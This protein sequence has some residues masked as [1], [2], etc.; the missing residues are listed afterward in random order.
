MHL[1]FQG[2]S[3]FLSYFL[4]C[5]FVAVKLSPL[6]FLEILLPGVTVCVTY[7]L[8]DP[9]HTHAVSLIHGL[10]LQI[11]LQP[12]LGQD[13]LWQY[14]FVVDTPM[15]T[16]S[17][18]HKDKLCLHCFITHAYPALFLISWYQCFLC[19]AML[20]V[21]H[22]LSRPLVCLRYISIPPFPSP[23]IFWIPFHPPIDRFPPPQLHREKC[24]THTV[25]LNYWCSTPQYIPTHTCERTIR[26]LCVSRRDQRQRER[27]AVPLREAGRGG[28]CIHK[29]WVYSVAMLRHG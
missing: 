3:G 28:L 21:I 7:S 15:H 6:G 13:L 9:E 2:S 23:P 11:E 25:M 4:R 24:Q 1:C 17:H 26:I 8:S 27:G 12:V 29:R 10:Q 14:P 19:H 18:T 16:H 22:Y 20:A 5:C